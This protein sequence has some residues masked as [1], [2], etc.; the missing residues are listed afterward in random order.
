[1]LCQMKCL[2][3]QFEKSRSSPTTGPKT[4]FKR[5]EENVST[6]LHIDKPFKIR[7]YCLLQRT[8]KNC[9]QTTGCYERADQW[10][11]FQGHS[12][13]LLR[14]HHQ[15]LG[16][17]TNQ[18]QGECALPIWVCDQSPTRPAPVNQPCHQCQGKCALPIWVC[19]P[20]PYSVTTI[21]LCIQNTFVLANWQQ[22]RE[23]LLLSPFKSLFGHLFLGQI[24][25]SACTKNKSFVVLWP[26]CGHK[27]NHKTRAQA[28]GIQ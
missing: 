22:F 17:H 1:M 6:H 13:N 10:I 11:L 3:S 23:H 7:V 8:K 20:I 2:K 25:F 16:M 28:K 4:R 24:P 27:T 15:R 12:N 26:K 5:E 19:D 21:Y 9:I 14:L 18:C